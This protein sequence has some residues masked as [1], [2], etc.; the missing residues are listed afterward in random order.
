MQKKLIALAVAGLVS[1]GAFAQSNVTIYGVADVSFDLVKTS[2]SAT[3][4]NTGNYSRVSTN[5]SLL[6][7]KGSEALGNGLNANFQFETAIDQDSVVGLIGGKRDTFVGLSGSFGDIKLGT[8]TTPTR[9]LGTAM[10]VNAGST[11]IGDNKALIDGANNASL[12]GAVSFDTRQNNTVMYT[13]QN[14]SGFSGAFAYVSGENKTTN[15]MAG[16]AAQLDGKTYDLGLTYNNGPILAGLTYANAKAGDTANSQSKNTRLAGKYNFG[17][18]DVR[19]LWNQAKVS[20]NVA[21]A[22]VNTWGLGG[23]FNATPNGKLIAQYIN[24]RDADTN[25]G[26]VANSNAKLFEIGYEHSLSKRTMLKAIY[27]KLSNDTASAINFNTNGTAG[28]AAGLDPQG[29]QF[30]IRHSF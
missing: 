30:G 6:G 15:A 25:V 5:G 10:D 1:G 18:G 28:V 29:F 16:T 21:W 12:A 20:T 23:S 3:N 4:T 7:F 8:L 2:G 13:S 11:G 26:K 24:S 27:A 14:Y 22:K 17:Q 9:A 19:L